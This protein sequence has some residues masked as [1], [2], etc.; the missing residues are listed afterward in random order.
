MLQSQMLLIGLPAAAALL[1]RLL[2]ARMAL[3]HCTAPLGA[4]ICK[5]GCN[6]L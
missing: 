2:I 1:Q 3:L 4:P 5:L 6:V